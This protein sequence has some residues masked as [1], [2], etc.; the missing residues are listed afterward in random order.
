MALEPPRKIRDIRKQLKEEEIEPEPSEPGIEPEP[1]PPPPPN[2]YARD[3]HEF[4][5]PP[6]PWR[7]MTVELTHDIINWWDH[8][9]WRNPIY[10]GEIT[11][12]EDEEDYNPSHDPGNPMYLP[13]IWTETPD[14]G[15]S[16][17][18][19][20]FYLTGT[21]L[22]YL[23]V[24]TDMNN[25]NEYLLERIIPKSDYDNM[26]KAFPG[27]PKPLDSYLRPR[28]W[29]YFTVYFYTDNCWG[30]WVRLH[31]YKF[32]E[33]DTYSPIDDF[34]WVEPAPQKPDIPSFQ[35]GED[36][37][38]EVPDVVPGIPDVP[39]FQVID[40]EYWYEIQDYG[41]QNGG[42]L[43]LC[44]SWARHTYKATPSYGGHYYYLK[45]QSDAES[46]LQR[47]HSIYADG[48]NYGLV[49]ASDGILTDIIIAGNRCK[50]TL[51]LFHTQLVK[52]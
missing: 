18:I 13:P 42:T 30:E 45:S 23:K 5:P 15:V 24:A 26:P 1:L 12:T 19:Q 47:R 49:T 41:P 36:E 46:I 37:A 4:R 20:D 28:Q 25:L 33:E 9:T 8:L 40:T 32:P 17:T 51:L 22:V 16:C 44:T 48:V 7:H 3:P 14:G 35:D 21:K 43:T 2:P 38:E 39:Q 52:Y 11:P 27:E 34:D 50:L 29:G 6:K 10:E 31:L